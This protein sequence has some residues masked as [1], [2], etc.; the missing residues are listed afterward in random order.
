M[1][2]PLSQARLT[3]TVSQ[4]LRGNSVYDDGYVRECDI[5]SFEPV[6]EQSHAENST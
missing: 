4:A 2:E 1:R 5:G 3:S 6:Q